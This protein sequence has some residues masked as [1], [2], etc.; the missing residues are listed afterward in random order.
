MKFLFVTFLILFS[1][2][3][4]AQSVGKLTGSI[5][6]NV[7]QQAVIGAKITLI[8]KNNPTPKRAL[9][10]T[11]GSYELPNLPYGTYSMM[12]TIL[13]FDTIQ[14]TVKMDKPLVKQDV[15]L[16]GSQEL[17]EVKVIGNLV[18]EGNVPV[19]VTKI[20]LQKITEELASRDLPMLLNGTAGVYATQTGGGDG[21]ARISVRGFDQ[22]NVGVLIDGVPVNDMENGSVT[23]P[24]GLD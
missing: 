11:E 19:A 10:N 17:D 1:T 7:T 12:V 8:E 4:F 6:D 16:G 9:T 22:R 14:M 15:V 18:R 13:T 5:V 21:D 2:L 20:S 23:G 24:I 3:S